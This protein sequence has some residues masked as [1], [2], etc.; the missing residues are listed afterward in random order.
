MCCTFCCY[1]ETEMVQ[2]AFNTFDADGS[3]EI[4]VKELSDFIS[5]LQSRTG[6]IPKTVKRVLS[7]FDSN[8][9]KS[10]GL[11]EFAEM[12]LKYPHLLWPAFRLQ[13]R[14][15]EMTLGLS[16]WKRLHRQMKASKERSASLTD[17]PPPRT[18]L[19][20]LCPCLSL[21][22]PPPTLRPPPPPTVDSLSSRRDPTRKLNPDRIRRKQSKRRKLSVLKSRGSRRSSFSRGSGEG[23]TSGLSRQATMRG[24]G[25]GQV[26]G[27]GSGGG[28]GSGLKRVD[29]VKGGGGKGLASSVRWAS[30][31]S[32]ESESGRRVDG[33][34]DEEDGRT[35]GSGLSARQRRIERGKSSASVH[36][37]GST[38]EQRRPSA[39]RTS[40]AWESQQRGSLSLHSKREEG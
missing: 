25:E 5:T 20:S 39:L 36:P 7:I 23:S 16:Q 11:D 21:P 40:S 26:N 12:N 32:A 29:T 8:D 9:S 33:G 28:G 27:G 2:F 24:G 22:P 1:T 30:G 6:D 3:G 38:T 31:S 18:P 17:P 15:Q 37:A 13:Y 10:I 4:G 19:H 14:V 35:G 34:S